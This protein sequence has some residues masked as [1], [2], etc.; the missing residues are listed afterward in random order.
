MKCRIEDLG[1]RDSDY[2]HNCT[3]DYA[4]MYKG[5]DSLK[6]HYRKY[7]RRTKQ[8]ELGGQYVLYCEETGNCITAKNDYMAMR[9]LSAFVDEQAEILR[10]G[11]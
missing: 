5:I 10:K 11:E 8:T 4:D 1:T 7:I 6:I 3:A 9:Q 2:E